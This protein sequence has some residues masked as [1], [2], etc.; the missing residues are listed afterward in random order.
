MIIIM[1]IGLIIASYII[2]KE[3]KPIDRAYIALCLFAA[4]TATTGITIFFFDCIKGDEKETVVKILNGD[5]K[6][7]TISM[8]KYG[9]LLEIEIIK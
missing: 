7:D 2:I 9:K 6:Y 8:D 5:I 1:I 3:Q 4:I